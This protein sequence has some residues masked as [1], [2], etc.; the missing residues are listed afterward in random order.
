MQ[1]EVARSSLGRENFD[2]NPPHEDHLST[3]TN[4][5]IKGEEEVATFS[6]EQENADPNRQGSDDP[7]SVETPNVPARIEGRR[8][9]L[10]KHMFFWKK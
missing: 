1:E 9:R 4:A 10:K 5:A 3:S 2:P 6:P 8:D 7:K